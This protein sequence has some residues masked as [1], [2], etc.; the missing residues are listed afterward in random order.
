MTTDSFTGNLVAGI[1]ARIPFFLGW[2]AVVAASFAIYDAVIFSKLADEVWSARTVSARIAA[3]NLRHDVESGVRLG[4]NLDHFRDL[5]RLVARARER[6][7]L[8]V[9]VLDQAGTVVDLRGDFPWTA[10][11][12]GREISRTGN[13]TVRE[14]DAGRTL[15]VAVAGPAGKT[16]GYAAARIERGEA[17][18]QITSQIRTLLIWQAGTVAAGLLLLA[19][20]GASRP[21]A[22]SG[23]A[24][25]RRQVSLGVLLL[26]MLCNVFAAV[27][28][29]GT[30]YTYRTRIDAQ[31]TGLLLADTLTRV[32]SLGVPLESGGRLESYLKDRADDLGG[33]LRFEVVDNQ[34]SK[35]AESSPAGAPVS[36]EPQVFALAMGQRAQGWVAPEAVLKVSVLEGPWFEKLRLTILNLMTLAAVAFVVMAELLGL[37]TKPAAAAG[38]S[39]ALLRPLA[40]A[41]FAGTHLTLCTALLRVAEMMPSDAGGRL[42]AMAGVLSVAFGVAGLMAF[43]GGALLARLGPKLMMASG[44]VVAAAGWAAAWAA[45]GVGELIAAHGLMG[46][47]WGAALL[48]LRSTAAAAHCG[49]GVRAGMLAGSLAGCV[50]GALLAEIIGLRHLFLLQAAIVLGL[51]P[52]CLAVLPGKAAA[53]QNSAPR[54]GVGTMLRLL[55]D[56]RVLALLVLVVAASSLVVAGT[57]HYL[58]VAALQ[59]GGAAPS[60]IGRIHLLRGLPLVLA[61]AWIGA[62]LEGL[63]ARMAAVVAGVLCVAAGA[64]LALV[65]T[66]LVGFSLA[67]LAMGVGLACSMPAVRRTFRDLPAALSAG[68]PAAMTLYELVR[69]AG[70]AAGPLVACAL[71]GHVTAAQASAVLGAVTALL[72]LVYLAVRGAG[73]GSR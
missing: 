17:R 45:P 33:T 26:V 35:L 21:G 9:A 19:L 30:D 43:A 58:S 41:A 55:A 73:S 39:A 51:V 1:K 54:A 50:L 65:S 70:L 63:P 3:D 56:A 37:G 12:D 18:A 29:L 20:A 46:L 69:C 52:V 48:A 47:G 5:D 57:S 27:Y 10:F 44:L 61:G 59:A 11:A 42:A 16:A 62:P 71:A 28:T 40:F 66:P 36:G 23:A 64:A 14:D 72:L 13:L 6:S 4:K 15:L 31:H 2:L 34:G 7:Q 22:G 38:R 49:R 24:R 53:A 67:A 8:P 68:T 32:A 60:D 25:S